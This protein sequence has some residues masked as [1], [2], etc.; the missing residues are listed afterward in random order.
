M[1][2]REKPPVF[3]H[4][5]VAHLMKGPMLEVRELI[6]N[7]AAE[8]AENHDVQIGRVVVRPHHYIEDDWTEVAFDIQLSS[9]DETAFSYWEAVCDAVTAARSGMSKDARESL[10]ARVEVIVD[11]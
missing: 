8:M 6:L 1:Q 9:D 10:D 3:V 5:D 7:L 2:T 4:P 11:W